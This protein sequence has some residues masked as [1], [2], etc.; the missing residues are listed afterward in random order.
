MNQLAWRTMTHLERIKANLLADIRWTER[1]I[2]ALDDHDAWKE[3]DKKDGHS[4]AT[5]IRARLERGVKLGQ[6]MT[7]DYYRGRARAIVQKYETELLQIAL[8]K[9]Q[10]DADNFT[11]QAQEATKQADLARAKVVEITKELQRGVTW[12]PYSLPK[13]H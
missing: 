9:A 2:V 8:F 3:D 5:F 4:T 1:A 10:A 13:F 7:S 12:R 11:K 6:C